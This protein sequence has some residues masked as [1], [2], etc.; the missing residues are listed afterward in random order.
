MNTL[1]D[2]LLAFMELDGQTPNSLAQ[3]AGIDGG[4]MRKMLSGKQTITEST[5]YKIADAH[6]LNIDWLKSGKEPMFI[7]DTEEYK[8]R[9]REPSD[10]EIIAGLLAQLKEKDR[11][12]A[13]RD[14]QIAEL[15]TIIKKQTI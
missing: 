15:M 1:I 14:L 5:L 6:G 10:R 2:R 8:N 12:L 13:A 9:L 3:K 7:A 11:Q 4:N